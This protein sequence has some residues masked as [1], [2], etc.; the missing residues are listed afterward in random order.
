MK[1]QLWAGVLLA[2]CLALSA[3]AAN[4]GGTVSDPASGASSPS[5]ASAAPA[6]VCFMDTLALSPAQEIAGIHYYA[7]TSPQDFEGADPLLHTYNP[8]LVAVFTEYLRSLMVTEQVPEATPLPD[9]AALGD[10]LYLSLSIANDG[11]IDRVDTLILTS[12]GDCY[13]AENPD[14]ARLYHMADAAGYEQAKAVLD[15][16]MESFHSTIAY[17][18]EMSV[19]PDHFVPESTVVRVSFYNNGNQPARLGREYAFEKLVDGSWKPLEWKIPQAAAAEPQI[20]PPKDSLTHILDLTAL[21]GGQR[22]G[23]YR[24]RN[25]VSTDSDSSELTAE[26]TISADAPERSNPPSPE[27]TPEHQESYD[28]YLSAWGFYSPFDQPFTEERYFTEF[29]TY[30][31]FGGCL[32]QESPGK[33]EEFHSQ[34]GERFPAELV[35]ST[36]QR[37]FLLSTATIRSSLPGT[38]GSGESFDAETGIYV[39]PGGYGGGSNHGVVTEA[40][41]QGD[42]LT[43]TCDWYGMDDSYQYTCKVTI[44]LGEGDAFHYIANEVS[45]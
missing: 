44:R 19:Y 40:E 9:S 27:M 22:E 34:Y 6:G 42:L 24:L 21:A 29:R 12:T 14:E 33:L 38:G 31:L 16:M 36:I 13:D 18:M 26:Y 11:N 8:A 43:L 41:R 15:K 30:L 2:C 23:T 35:E 45:R 17:H 5:E 32:W 7:S 10:F 1:K 3:C 4:G 28:R 25:T 20:V 39:F 37:H